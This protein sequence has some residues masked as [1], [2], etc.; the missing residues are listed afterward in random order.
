MK[1]FLKKIAIGIIGG[2]VVGYF[3]LPVTASINKTLTT[4]PNLETGLVNHWTLDGVNIDTPQ[5]TAEIR[6]RVGGKHGDNITSGA[7]SAGY[8][9]TSSWGAGTTQAPA[10]SFSWTHNHSGGNFLAVGVSIKNGSVTVS[11]ITYNGVTMKLTHATTST[12]AD[13]TYRSEIWHL[14]NPTSGSNTIA[15]TLTGVPSEVH[16]SAVSLSDISASDPVDVTAS[17]FSQANSVTAS[18]TTNVANTVA[19]DVLSSSDAGAVVVNAGQT[20]RWDVDM[21]TDVHALGTEVIATAGANSAGWSTANGETNVLAVAVFKGDQPSQAQLVPGKIGQG[22]EFNRATSTNYIDLGNVG[23]TVRSIA[24]WV[25]VDDATSEKIIDIDGTD[26]IETN[27][28]DQITGTSFPGSV[29]YYVD[30]VAGARVLKDKKWHHVV[31]TDTTGVSPT[32]MDIGRV[33]TAYFQGKI[34]D[35]RFYSTVLTQA[36]VTRLSGLGQTTKQNKTITTNPDFSNGLVLHWTFDAP[37]ISWLQTNEI[38]DISGNGRDGNVSDLVNSDVVSGKIGQAI[39]MQTIT[40]YVEYSTVGAFPAGDFAYSFWFKITNT[41][42]STIF[43]IPGSGSNDEFSIKVSS[44]KLRIYTNNTLQLTT[45]QSFGLNKWYHV[46]VQ[47]S[48]SAVTV[49]VN[50]TADPTT[51]TDATALSFTC[52][53]YLGADFNSS[54][55]T[56]LDPGLL[57]VDDFRVYNRALGASE[58][59]RLYGMGATTK[60]N[61]TLTTNSDLNNGL[62][63]HYTFDG[64]NMDWSQADV[65]RDRGSGAAHG[66]PSQTNA[67]VVPGVIGQALDFPVS[68]DGVEVGSPTLPTGGFTYTAW[69]YPYSATAAVNVVLESHSI[70]AIGEIALGFTNGPFVT[71][72]VDGTGTQVTGTTPIPSRKWSHIAVTRASSGGAIKVYLNGRQDGSGTDSDTLSFGCAL[73]IGYQEFPTGAACLGGTPIQTSYDGRIDD[74]RVYDRELSSA[75]ILRLYQLGD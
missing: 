20:E 24:F 57:V 72:Y 31:I 11:N 14:A 4:N 52:T 67:E 45:T 62:V 40:R 21:G 17:G 34:D 28:S 19:I 6:D 35:L 64:K 74:V 71:A 59:S 36:D 10:S 7:M 38:L 25:Y 26:Q 56:A 43:D 53:A 55:G 49:Y 41:T 60:V 73:T 29:T 69:I 33:G 27:A 65:V 8:V 3:V 66:N 23:G 44:S 22:L 58:I 16:A 75:E 46:V 39:Y 42:D 13:G 9:T 18:Y 32:N 37:N 12:T 2:I 48:G 61:T 47:R 68:N 5:T 70:A 51:G 50:G 15:V 30:G 1:N 63:H 54:C